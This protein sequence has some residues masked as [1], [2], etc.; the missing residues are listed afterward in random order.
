M[1]FKPMSREPRLYWLKSGKRWSDDNNFAIILSD[2][3]FHLIPITDFG[4]LLGYH[5]CSY[6]GRLAKLYVSTTIAGGSN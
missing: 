6:S 2:W 1:K 3:G 4:C 5:L